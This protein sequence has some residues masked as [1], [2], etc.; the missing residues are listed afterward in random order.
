MNSHINSVHAHWE[1]GSCYYY[2]TDS[3]TATALGGARSGLPQLIYT[4]CVH[5]KIDKL[6]FFVFELIV[7]VWNILLGGASL[8][9]T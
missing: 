5:L 4:V 2:E 1:G 8:S 9:G 6:N 3:A 7:V